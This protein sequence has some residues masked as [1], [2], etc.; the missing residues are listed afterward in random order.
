MS[1]I[2]LPRQSAVFLLDFLELLATQGIMDGFSP[3]IAEMLEGVFFTVASAVCTWA[4]KNNAQ[5][6]GLPVS[7]PA[8]LVHGILLG[9]SL[10]SF[11]LQ[12]GQIFPKK[13]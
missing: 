2:F 3:R 10:A 9:H 13:K 4:M 8:D 7:A 5:V 11:F 6:G 1:H 12:T